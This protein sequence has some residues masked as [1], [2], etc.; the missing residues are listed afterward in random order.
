M[1]TLLKIVRAAFGVE[2]LVALVAIAAFY[3]PLGPLAMR[4]QRPMAIFA[5]LILLFLGL[6]LTS[7]MAWWSLR[8]GRPKGK[9]WVLRPAS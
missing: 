1:P 2:A 5:G 7:A 3:G 4:G 6:F 9:W 8:S